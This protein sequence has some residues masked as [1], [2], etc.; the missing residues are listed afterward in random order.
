MRPPVRPASVR[1]L[2]IVGVIGAL[3]TT[4]TSIAYNMPAREAFRLAGIAG[5]AALL[6]GAAG[7]TLLH[8]L[9]RRALGIQLTVAALASVGAVGAGAMVAADA[10]FISQHDLHTL[11]VILLAAGTV[12]SLVALLLGRR[13]SAAARSLSDAARRIGDGDLAVTV[14]DPFTGEFADLARELD[15]MA[16]RLDEARQKE[17]ALEASRRELTAWVSHDLRTPLA[18]IRAM[19]EALEDGVVQDPESVGRYYRT[20]RIE[21]E[22]L[23]RLVDE[24]F[25]LSVINAGALRLQMERASLGDLV[26]DAIAAAGPSARARRVRIEGQLND[27]GL[28]LELSP[29][30]VARVLRNLLDNAVQHTPSDGAVWV[31]A[32][33]DGAQAYVTVADECGGIPEPVLERV[34]DAAFRGEKARTPG[35]NGGA[36]LG[37]AIARGIVEAHHGAITVRNEGPGCR[38]TV[39]LPLS[40]SR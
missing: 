19:A 9:R 23:A 22:R 11:L 37:L 24:L 34:F 6:V 2:V 14:A 7:T 16:R 12:G 5:G 1:S 35:S 31:E 26:S 32:G 33:V 10:M 29:S 27:T 30:N 8:V 4:I 25:E 3:A 38:F 13:V 36:G 28:D 15:T 40:Q 39:R 17:R 18:G 20:L 21:S